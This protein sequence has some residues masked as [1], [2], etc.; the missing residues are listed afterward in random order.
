MLY[1]FVAVSQTY[2][3]RFLFALTVVDRREPAQLCCGGF[4]QRAL[5]EAWGTFPIVST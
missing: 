5:W 1:K 2:F 3:P 4:G